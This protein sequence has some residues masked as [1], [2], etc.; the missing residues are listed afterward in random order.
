[1]TTPKRAIETSDDSSFM[2]SLAAPSRLSSRVRLVGVGRA[3]LTEFFYKIPSSSLEDDDPSKSL[4]ETPVV[5]AEFKL[6]SDSSRASQASLADIGTKGAKSV[7]SAPVFFVT[8]LSNLANSVT[9]LHDER[10]RLS[11]ILVA[12]KARLEDLNMFED[13]DGIGM[14]GDLIDT[15]EFNVLKPETPNSMN[16]VVRLDNYGVNVF[17]SFASINAL[18]DAALVT[19]VQDFYSPE[20]RHM[21]EHRLEMLSFV[22]F[23]ALSGYC[24][25]ADVG[26]ALQS[27]NTAERLSRAHELMME[28][29]VVLKRLASQASEDLTECGEEC[30]DLW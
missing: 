2:E 29:V 19:D 13:S 22:A 24:T 15:A 23:R 18:T 9:R 20:R 1:M 26:W 8:K 17:S 14:V 10:R 27:T 11:Q 5:M 21:E 7:D 25:A 4:G 28:H 3:S 30:T 16:D 12:A 6:I